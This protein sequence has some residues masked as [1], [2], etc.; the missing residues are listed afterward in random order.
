MAPRTYLR[1]AHWNVSLGGSHSSDRPSNRTHAVADRA[2]ENFSKTY[3]KVAVGSGKDGILEPVLTKSISA[4]RAALAAPGLSSS[5][6]P[7]SAT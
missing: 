3:I 6:T 1:L 4:E 2:D 7:P 5:S